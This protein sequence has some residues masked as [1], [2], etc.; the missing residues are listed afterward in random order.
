MSHFVKPALAYALPVFALAFCLGALRVTLVEPRIGPLAAVALE[1][2]VVLALSWLVAGAVLRRWPQDWPRRLAMG[3]LAFLVLMALELATALSFG[4]S[5]A[6]FL[7]AMAT[8][9]G[10]LGL[11]GQVGFG[12]IPALRP[13]PSG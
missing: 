6:G 7:A 4:Q 9:A 12:L 2:P 1:V 10:L 13:Q 5:A 11:A 3:A 8:P